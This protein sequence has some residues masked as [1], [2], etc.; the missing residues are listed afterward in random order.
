MSQMCFKMLNLP[1]GF[2]CVLAEFHL[3]RSCCLFFGCFMSFIKCTRHMA[4]L[5]PRGSAPSLGFHSSQHAFCSS[6]KQGLVCHSLPLP[7]GCSRCLP[8]TGRRSGKLT[9][10]C[11]IAQKK[12]SSFLPTCGRIRKTWQG[13]DWRVGTHPFEDT[14]QLEQLMLVITF[15]LRVVMC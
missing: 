7:T 5:T 15:P 11:F 8:H 3:H 4:N 9:F 6:F 13:M 10:S 1:H 2:S 12:K 14:A